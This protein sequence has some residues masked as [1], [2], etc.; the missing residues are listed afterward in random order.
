[1][2]IHMLNCH[3]VVPTVARTNKVT[4]AGVVCTV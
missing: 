3:S 1:M 2:Y 4:R